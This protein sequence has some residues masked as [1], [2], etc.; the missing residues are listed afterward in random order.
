MWLGDPDPDVIARCMPIE[1]A[2]DM[3][4]Y[5]LSSVAQVCTQT[6][7]G[8]LR[9]GF[10]SF[11]SGHSSIAFAGLGYLSLYVGGHVRVLDNRGQVWKM[12]LTVIPTL[13]A[14]IIACTRITD[15]WHHGTDVLAG[16]ILGATISY[17]S[18][19]QYFPSLS[20]SEKS[21]RAW[22]LRTWASLD[23]IPSGA[24]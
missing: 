2:K 7:T 19:R 12:I 23:G 4:P 16:S 17:I 6:N 1:G 10:R 3:S 13:A 11:P 15:H 14:T 22:S 18:Y 8:L 5:G 21:G 9:E 24:Y 20:D